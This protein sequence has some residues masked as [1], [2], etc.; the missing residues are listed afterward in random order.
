M[1]VVRFPRRR[2]PDLYVK[3]ARRIV[4]LAKEIIKQQ[5][6]FLGRPTVYGER[7]RTFMSIRA[8]HELLRAMERCHRRE[9]RD[10]K[11]LYGRRPR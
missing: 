6:T 5:E 9:E 2:R 4:R 1:T 10:P 7:W 11:G 8:A 3:D